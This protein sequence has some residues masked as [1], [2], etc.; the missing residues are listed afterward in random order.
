MSLKVNCICCGHSLELSDSYE[1]YEGEV[2]CWTCR[3]MLEVRFEEGKLRSM[4][5]ARPVAPES[6]REGIRHL[7]G[8][9]HHAPN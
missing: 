4:K 8:D 6:R 1:D 3:G 7:E 5:R 2:R 9:D